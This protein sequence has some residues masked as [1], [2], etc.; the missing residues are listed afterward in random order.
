[1]DFADSDWMSVAR[2][3][4]CDRMEGWFVD[5]DLGYFPMVYVQIIGYKVSAKIETS[6]D[7]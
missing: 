3:C 4:W 2:A 7:V 6:R 1:M 5:L